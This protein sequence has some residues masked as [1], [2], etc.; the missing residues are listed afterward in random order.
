MTVEDL[1]AY[2]SRWADCATR[3]QSGP[4]QGEWLRQ[5]DQ[6]STAY[7]ATAALCERMDQTN[8]L[9]ERIAIQLLIMTPP[10]VIPSWW[11]A[12]PP[13]E[14]PTVTSMEGTESDA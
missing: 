8:A 12:T 6:L 1:K 9:L 11:T 13:A 7:T 4:R 14:P 2:A 5:Y 3:E 10:V